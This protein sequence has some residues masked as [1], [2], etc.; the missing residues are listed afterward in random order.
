MSLSP[1]R[2][3]PRSQRI[4]RSSAV[5]ISI[6]VHVLFAL[7]LLSNPAAAKK[8]S[9]WVEV[10][11]NQPKPPPPPPPPEPEP[12]KPEPPKPKPPPKVVKF[13]DTKPVPQPPTPAPPD[14]TPRRVVR[15]IQGL[16]A[17]SFSTGANTGLTVRAGNT[18]ATA[19]TKDSMSLADATGPLQPRPY[20]AV[21]T[22]PHLR[23]SPTMEVPEEA[24]KANI[25]GTIP[26]VLDIDEKGKVVKVTVVHGLGYGTDEACAAAWRKAQWKPGQQDGVAVGVTGIPENCEVIATE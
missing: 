3:V 10:A 18:T 23:W 22:A 4:L 26:V 1:F 21:T 6:G 8:A 9:E 14:P 7:F 19:A 16:T 25:K 20:T 12:P 2:P 17:N 11:I 13:E 15:P 24:K 5:G